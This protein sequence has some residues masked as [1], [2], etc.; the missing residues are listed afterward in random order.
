VV[1][2]LSCSD[3]ADNDVDVPDIVVEIR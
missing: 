1:F 3:A 2:S